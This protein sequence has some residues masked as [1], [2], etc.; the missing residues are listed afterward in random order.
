MCDLTMQGTPPILR[1][2]TRLS[3]Q[4]ADDQVH[5]DYFR[6]VFF[7]MKT[8]FALPNIGPVATAEGVAKVERKCYWSSFCEDCSWSSLVCT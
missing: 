1:A 4:K 8:G 5:S 2:L 6:K 7:A 3:V